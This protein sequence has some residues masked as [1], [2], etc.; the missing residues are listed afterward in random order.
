MV[1][2]RRP[3]PGQPAA[4]RRRPPLAWRAVPAALRGLM[5]ALL[6][7]L[8]A[9]LQAGELAGQVLLEPPYPLPSQA[10]L[11][12]QLLDVSL[13]DAPAVLLGRSRLL[14]QGP[15]PYAFRLSYLEGAIR[16]D[17]RYQLRATIQEGQRLL[18]TTDTAH[19][20]LDGR[21]GPLRLPLVPVGDAPLRGLTW[22][23][24]PAA[25]VPAPPGAPRLEQQI[26]LDPVTRELSGSAD[27]NRFIGSFRLE[28]EQL[29]LEPLA[30]TAQLCE[31]EVMADEQS[32]LET[33]RQVRRWHV[34]GR[35]R[36]ELRGG[37]NA[38][39]LLLETRPRP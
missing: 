33:L 23:R 1:L 32:F 16:A 24:A 29:Q 38:P 22:L 34:D 2:L 25:S 10:V 36:L 14:P 30:G 17:R 6:A 7:L 26:R 12:V 11:D 37:D 8:P 3:L 13:A 5:P 39:L 9:A 15:P 28:G 18:F 35:G 4:P 27:C 19:P 31:P 20:V 21:T